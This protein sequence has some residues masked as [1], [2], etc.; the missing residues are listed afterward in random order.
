MMPNLLK[1][2]LGLTL[3]IATVGIATFQSVVNAGTMQNN[4]AHQSR[5]K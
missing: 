5:L 4:L 1:K 3:L 2:L